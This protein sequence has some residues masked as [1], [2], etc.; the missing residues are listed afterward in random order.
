MATRAPPSRASAPGPSSCSVRANHL[1]AA[2]LPNSRRALPPAWAARVPAPRPGPGPR[3]WPPGPLGRFARGPARG[4]GFEQQ[5][6]DGRPPPGPGAPAAG[7]AAK[8]RCSPSPCSSAAGLGGAGEG[9]HHRPGARGPGG[10][11][12]WPPSRP[13]ARTQWMDR[14]RSRA[15]G[16]AQLG[17][18]GRLLGRRGRAGRAAKSRP[19]SP[20]AGPGGV[21]RGPPG[22][23]ASPGAAWATNQGCRPSMGSTP[24]WSRARSSTGSQSSSRVAQQTRS[25]HPGRPGPRPAP[26]EPGRRSADPGGGSGCRN[27]VI[28]LQSITSSRRAV[29][30]ALAEPLER[31]RISATRA[32]RAPGDA[33]PGAGR[34]ATGTA[35]AKDRRRPG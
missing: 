9:V 20:S 34:W 4:V 29:R 35:G 28:D 25:V 23:P 7:R 3:P 1:M 13:Q 17:H 33:V 18:E 2:S 22:A 19:H 26:R 30:H 16:Q 27:V 5:P 10:R 24:G 32:P 14:G 21:Q 11:A 31:R 8:D 12:A 6:V 15:D